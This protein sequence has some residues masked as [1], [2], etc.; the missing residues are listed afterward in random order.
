MIG[1]IPKY[2]W[3]KFLVPNHKIDW[4]HTKTYIKVIRTYKDYQKKLETIFS[5][6]STG[7]FVVISFVEILKLCFSVLRIS[8]TSYHLPYPFLCF[9]QTN[10]W[11]GDVM[12]LASS[13]PQGPGSS[14]L[15]SQSHNSTTSSVQLPIA[16]DMQ[17]LKRMPLTP[18]LH[19]KHAPSKTQL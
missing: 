1:A 3:R 13:M 15:G 8:F 17:L 10:L 7:S 4:N 16:L 18:I 5:Q 9:A 12:V 19:H 6:L 2:W 11:R 14:P